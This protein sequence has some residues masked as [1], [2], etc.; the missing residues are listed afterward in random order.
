MQDVTVDITLGNSE[1]IPAN[2]YLIVAKID[3]TQADGPELGT[4]DF[5]KAIVGFAATL[6]DLE[7]LFFNQGYNPVNRFQ[8]IFLNFM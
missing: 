2:G 8:N 6:P 3:P 1:V 7:T 4:V 5:T